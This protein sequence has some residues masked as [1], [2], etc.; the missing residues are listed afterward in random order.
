M[1]KTK[2]LIKR[3]IGT[4]LLPLLPQRVDNLAK[5]EFSM[6]VGNRNFVDSCLRAGLAA[7]MLRNDRVDVLSHY[8]RNFWAGEK[9]TEFHRH[10]RD[11]VVS[12]YEDHFCYLADEINKL[13]AQ[14]PHFNT[15]VEIGAG[16][17]SFLYR[18][19]QDVHGVDNVIGND[20]SSATTAEN[21][22]LYPEIEW[23]AGDG[24]EWVEQNGIANTIYITFRGVLEYFTQSDLDSLFATI[25]N[26]KSPSALIIVE[27]ISLDH[28]LASQPNSQ[29]YGTEYSFSHN[30]PYLIE[31]NDFTIIRSDLKTFD[32]HRICA[33]VAITN[34]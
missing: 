1:G 26:D 17:G 33:I 18:L 2:E 6:T 14:H 32:T 34:E 22:Q 30:Y 20:L 5:H 28:D 23:V 7:H 27:P 31:K 3:S 24:K 15:I 11:Q 4:V 16:G 25:S 8:H 10:V 9:G 21:Q 13:V 29:A 12:A 19:M